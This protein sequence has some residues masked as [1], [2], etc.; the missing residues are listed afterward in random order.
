MKGIAPIVGWVVMGLALLVSFGID[1]Y[2]IVGGGATDSYKGS[3]SIDFR[4][5]ITGVRLLAHDIDPYHYKWH[6]GGPAEYC[7]PFNNV[8]VPVSK[9]TATPGLLILHLPLA[10]MPYRSAQWAWLVLQWL[11]LLGTAAIWLR[12]CATEKQR[13]MLAAF[14]TGLTYTAAW[15]LHAERGQIYVVIL[16]IFAAW[17]SLTFDPK[18]GNGFLAGFVAGF[19]GTLRPP[20]LAILPFVALHRR[21]QL[22]G[23]VVGLLVGLVLPMLWDG[24]VWPQYFSAMSTYADI[25]RTDFDPHTPQAYPPEIDGMP[26]DL[27]ANFQIISYADFSAHAFLKWMNAEPFPSLLVLMV[28]LVPY[29]FWLWYSR[30]EKTEKLLLGLVAWMFIIDLFL[31]AYRNNYNDV[32]ALNLV[33]LGLVGSSRIPLGIWPCLVA[34]PLGWWV[35]VA[36]PEQPLLID[37][38][39]LCFTIGAL[40]LLFLPGQILPKKSA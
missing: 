15:R 4:N 6:T 29:G 7:D 27:I 2:N 12:L 19:L 39:S 34:L 33:A 16:F 20:L 5:R 1:G 32:L 35:Y 21:G 17:L 14:V 38:P 10:E 37:L 23:A 3:G 40:L 24:N 11:F 25:Y 30:A 8:N 31:P 26:V 22:A 18:R 36:A 28:A 9:T 13:L